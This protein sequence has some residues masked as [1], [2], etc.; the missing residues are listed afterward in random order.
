[1][2]G[3]VFGLLGAILL[4]IIGM[5]VIAF[6]LE[7]IEEHWEYVLGLIIILVAFYWL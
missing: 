3:L 1:M 4:I 2:I 7:V 6:V 5:W